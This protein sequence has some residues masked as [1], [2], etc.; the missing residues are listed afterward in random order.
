VLIGLS[1]T[2]LSRDVMDARALFDLC[3]AWR[4]GPRWPKE[5]EILGQQLTEFS[6]TLR[7]ALARAGG[8]NEPQNALKAYRSAY[9]DAKRIFEQRLRNVI[10]RTDP[11]PD[12]SYDFWHIGCGHSPKR[13]PVQPV[14]RYRTFPLSD[15]ANGI[16]EPLQE[17]Y[18]RAP[19]A[20]DDLAWF[21]NRSVDS[22]RKLQADSATR[23]HTAM[24]EH[25]GGDSPKLISLRHWIL[26]HYRSCERAWLDATPE[27]YRFK[28]VVYVHHV[29]TAD[30]LRPSRTME[31]HPDFG[32]GSPL[33]GLKGE[34]RRLMLGT[35]AK[36][37]RRLPTLFKNGA[38]ERPT[39]ELTGRLDA[40]GWSIRALKRNVT[41]LLAAC[42]NARWGMRKATVAHF[43][44][45]VAAMDRTPGLN[46]FLT[47]VRSRRDLRA[48]VFCALECDG[49]ARYDGEQA[50]G[51][52]R[53]GGSAARLLDPRSLGLPRAKLASLV[54][55]LDRKLPKEVL[56]PGAVADEVLDLAVHRI[57]EIVK[58]R[59]DW[60]DIVA[61]ANKAIDRWEARR[62]RPH[63]A[64]EFVRGLANPTQQHRM[65]PEIVV[66][67]GSDAN[68]RA[69]TIDRFC[70]PGNPFVLVLT[71]VCTLGVDL[72]SFCWDVLHYT[73]AWTP[74]EFE[75]KTGR[76]DRPRLADTLRLLQLGHGANAA[77]VRV[78]HLVWPFT[79]DERILSRLHLRAQLS[80]RLLGTR[81]HGRFENAAD[82][83]SLQREI[84]FLPPLDLCP[85]GR[86]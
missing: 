66:Q 35:C 46:R 25:G 39:R 45:T 17:A 54:R 26:A 72:H 27:E 84:G 44:A 79:Y 16:I 61:R 47:V 28:L 36:L 71:N 10:V 51:R 68:T 52:S 37:A 3:L 23:S 77:R 20:A 41:L 30:A 4:K 50:S 42:L 34:L 82:P 56:R 24:M 53:R 13:D 43:M 48:R 21:I 7:H 6:R 2:L 29:R 8:K 22:R 18:A 31:E 55:R 75:Q 74:H 65:P 11:R 81:S 32:S 86:T 57:A 49:L 58:S 5:R 33:G 38:L 15:T 73:P 64:P 62:H 63:S 85:R 9:L 12:R 1:A 60:W 80:E 67:T 14:G 19:G 78:H 40:G 59:E 76:I 83:E 70:S 69:S